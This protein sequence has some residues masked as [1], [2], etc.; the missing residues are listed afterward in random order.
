M[1]I[2]DVTRTLHPGMPTWPGEPGPELT[3]IK[4]MAA[5]NPADV[6][7]LA[8]GVHTGTHVDAPRH[9]IPGGA[10]VESLP[11]TALIGPARVVTIRHQ[12]A[13][14]LEELESAGL[15]GIKRVLFRTRNS[16][17]WSDSAFKADFVYLEPDAAQWLADRGT[18]LIGVDYL[19]V[20]S[21]AA[22]EPLTHRTL[23]NAGVVIVEGLDLREIGDGDYALNCLPIK[24]AGAD[25]APARVVLMRD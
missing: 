3:L 25:G 21:Y 6:S 11:L 16:D 9:F 12:R 1:K 7:H 19:S 20:E 22:V 10:G 2:Y 8:L 17:D 18:L 23:L 15:E 13:I 24:L 4:E 14:T 5:G